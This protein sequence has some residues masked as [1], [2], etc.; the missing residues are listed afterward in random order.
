V[1]AP[2]LEAEPPPPY[3][4]PYA[5]ERPPHLPPETL[6]WTGQAEDAEWEFRLRLGALPAALVGA[7]WF[8][9]TF[10]GQWLVPI[11]FV[12]WLHESGHAVTAWLCGYPAFPGPW[13]T[14][15]GGTRAPLLALLAAAGLAYGVWRGRR[16]RRRRLVV[17]CGTVLALQFIGTVLLSHATAQQ[18]IYFG[19]DGGALV[20]GTLLMATVYAP[21]GSRL[22]EGWLRWGFLVIGASG[23][24]CKFRLW[25][26]AS[27]DIG[28]IP[29]GGNEGM[30]PSDPSVLADTYHW[31]V[32]QLVHRYVG[33][34]WLCLGVLAVLYALGL[35]Q[36]HAAM[37]AT[38][39][40]QTP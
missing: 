8:G 7:W 14:P 35:R 15:V 10:L 18:L 17:G 6:K 13:A 39:Q 11:F 20:L 22:R 34:G 26:G 4:P 36:A 29:F 31:S 27:N 16:E 12:M 1:A 24:T 40:A 2:A 30:G 37:R 5:P 19:G 38:T 21:A 9:T 28:L 3:F 32:N 23:F 33:L 25:L